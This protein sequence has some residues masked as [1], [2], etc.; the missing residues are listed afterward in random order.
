MKRFGVLIFDVDGTLAETEE[1][2][3][4]AFNET[5][6]YFDLGWEWSVDLYRDLLRVTGGKERIRRFADLRPE[7]GD[8]VSDDGIAELH[9]FK[10]ARFAQLMAT[11]ACTLRPGVANAIYAASGRGQRLAIATTTS[12]SNVDAIFSATL[13][14]DGTKLFSAIVAGDEV[15]R[16][17]PA[18]D[19]YLKVLSLLN[20]SN[21][22]CLAIEDSRNGFVSASRAGIPTLITRSTYFRDDEFDGALAVVDTL[23]DL[24]DFWIP[25]ELS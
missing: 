6:A 10:T 12:R 20:A 19:A 5:F 15:C 17:K 11:G 4:R 2:H 7:C 18:P 1:I 9:R 24:A 22:E 23:D 21:R 3:R 13:G 14:K 16:K 8:T 25:A